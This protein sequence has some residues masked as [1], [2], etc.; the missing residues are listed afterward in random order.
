MC[1]QRYIPLSWDWINQKQIKT[2]SKSNVLSFEVHAVHWPSNAITMTKVCRDF[3]NL[4][5]GK[6][7]IY[8]RITSLMILF[9][10][11]QPV[12]VHIVERNILLAILF[13][14]QQ[15][16]MV[17]VSQQCVGKMVPLTRGHTHAQYQH[18][19]HK[20]QP[21]RHP[22]LSLQQQQVGIYIWFGK[23]D[24]QLYDVRFTI[25]PCLIMCPQSLVM[26]VSGHHGM[27]PAS[28]HLE[29]QEET[30]KHL[31]TLEKQGTRYVTTQARSNVELR[32]FLMSPLM[33]WDKWCSVTWLRGWHAEMKTNQDHWPCAL[34]TKSEFY[35]VTLMHAQ[36]HLLLQQLSQPHHLPQLKQQLQYLQ[37]LQ[38][39][40]LPLQ[41]LQAQHQSLQ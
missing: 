37:L 23:K 41:H 13:T 35:V 7:Q 6:V 19:Q 14:T 20:C 21:V 36:Q 30:M 5:V 34:T 11:L 29:L 33:M 12:I 38:Q 3:E 15:M 32:N 2:D 10:S 17:T 8:F 28:Q 26:P 27:T 4:W 18:R 1:H 24:I 39:S 16:D 40:Q 31:Q 22:P 9:L 25:L